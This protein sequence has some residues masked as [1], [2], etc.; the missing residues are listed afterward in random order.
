M[1]NPTPITCCDLA[2]YA[3][4]H[5][6]D[7][8]RQA[9]TP[10]FAKTNMNDMAFL[11]KKAKAMQFFFSNDIKTM[12]ATNQQASGRCWLF[13]ATNVL[14]EIIAKKLN[15]DSFELSQSYL[16]FWDKFERINYYIESVI[17]TAD[18]AHNSRVVDHIV[19]TGVH[20]GGQWD[21][22]VNIVKKYGILPK[23]CYPETFQSSNTGNVNKH[24]NKYLRAK[25][26]AL[27]KLAQE[28]KCDELKAL[29]EEM[30][31]KTFS[32]LCAA[33]DVPP[34]EFDFEYKNKDGKV[35]VEKGLTPLTFAEK[36]IGNYLDDYVSIIHAPTEDKPFDKTYTV[37]YLGN[38]VGGADVCYL[39]L[40][41]DEFK[42]AVADQL[43]DG[44]IV[45]FGSDC[46]KYNDGAKAAWD[47]EQFNEEI[48]TGLD[49]DMTKEDML[50]Y[51]VSQ[52]NHAMCIT[53]VNIDEETGE[54]NRWKIENSWGSGGANAGYHMASDAWFDLY[55]YQAVVNKKYLGEKAAL[56][57]GE[58]TE[59]E[60]W[61]PMGSLAD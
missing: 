27:R 2:K 38:V 29:R 26:A 61:D 21:M 37:K 59:L 57:D 42:K 34:T 35:I 47:V 8:V 40:R 33:Y 36:Y 16:A 52:M 6:D 43:K 51:H 4:Y 18:E 46:G 25:T 20:D 17:D 58:M 24:V 10:V 53:G 45:W 39:N 13:A 41:M 19:G 49:A 56:L 60:P 54:P 30:L 11:T 5:T 32:F 7:A 3:Q 23:V 14:R 50:N 28:K 1:K 44:E 15:V 55:V 22:F 31:E 48:V 9:M 12:A